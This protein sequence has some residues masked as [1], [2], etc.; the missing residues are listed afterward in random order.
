MEFNEETLNIVK[1]IKTIEELLTLAK[2]HNYNI[3]E[4]EAKSYFNYLN[5]KSGEISDYELANVAGGACG[6]KEN[7]IPEE[8][9]V[10]LLSL[11]NEVKP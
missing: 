11:M 2:E 4:E 1:Q 10:S 3:T 9:I 5:P 6:N 7:E 8:K